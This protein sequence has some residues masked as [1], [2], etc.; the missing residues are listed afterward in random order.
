[1]SS[2]AGE[3]DQREKGVSL[4][5]L[6]AKGTRGR[7]GIAVRTRLS[8]RALCELESSSVPGIYCMSEQND[9]R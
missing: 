6:E 7:G 1:M 2:V 4:R 5:E 8:N 9:L 3:E